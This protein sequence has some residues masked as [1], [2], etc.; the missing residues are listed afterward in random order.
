MDIYTYCQ[1]SEQKVYIYISISSK[2][3]VETWNCQLLSKQKMFWKKKMNM[4]NIVRELWLNKMAIEKKKSLWYWFPC[5][6]TSPSSAAAVELTGLQ[7]NLDEL[8][9]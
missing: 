3:H 9:Q 8:I 2:N 7:G 4:E 5:W 6:F 1:R